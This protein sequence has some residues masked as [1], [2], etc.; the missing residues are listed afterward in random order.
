MKTGLRNQSAADFGVE[1]VDEED[2][3][4][5]EEVRLFSRRTRIKDEL[6]L[7]FQRAQSFK[8]SMKQSGLGLLDAETEAQRSDHFCNFSNLINDIAEHD[9]TLSRSRE[10]QRFRKQWPSLNHSLSPEERRVQ[11]DCLSAELSAVKDEA[12]QWIEELRNEPKVTVGV[13]V[14]SCFDV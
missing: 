11:E 7:Q 13:Q 4:D 5:E 12:S 9:R 6:L 8:T 10:Q 2:E 14:W 3:D 1:E